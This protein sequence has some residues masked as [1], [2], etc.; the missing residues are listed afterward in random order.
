MFFERHRIMF[1]L[2]CVL[3]VLII[4]S[5][6]NI[7]YCSTVLT[8]SEY[9][10]KSN[11]VN[12]DI[13]FVA[14]SD[15]EG[16]T[17]G[18]DNSRLAEKIEGANPEFVV[19]LG[20]MVKSSNGNF[21]GVKNL[22]SSLSQKY[23]VFYIPG[24]HECLN[25]GGYD[26]YLSVLSSEINK[27]GAKFLINEMT[28]YTTKNG[29]RLTIA[30]LKGYP[31]YEYDAPEYD[32]EENHL[33]QSYLDQEDE[34]H[35]SLLLCHQPETYMWGLENYKID[36]M[37][38]GHT[39]GGVVRLPFV[40]GLYAPEQEWFPRYDKGYYSNGKANMIISSG[41]DGAGMVPR[42]NNPLEVTVVTIKSTK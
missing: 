15:T 19:I 9:E 23:P 1:L 7:I 14:I 21:A 5:L 17:F 40:G 38:C 8:Y 42:F 20:D 35:L 30:G 37:L 32:N 3:A 39:H 29:D 26:D 2:L 36:L 6:V 4:F 13:K 34:N 28:E 18:K 27:T 41:L 25:F 24:N 11:K 31:F 10:I 22:C 16:N 33:F 12:N